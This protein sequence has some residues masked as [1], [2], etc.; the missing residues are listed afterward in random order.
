MN[1]MYT[2]VT[3]AEAAD[4][5]LAIFGEHAVRACSLSEWKPILRMP[6]FARNGN[7]TTCRYII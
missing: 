6:V 1:A 3:H 5:I 4:Q 2:A 7:A